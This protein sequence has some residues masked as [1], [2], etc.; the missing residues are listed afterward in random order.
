MLLFLPRLGLRRGFAVLGG[1][2]GDETGDERV[3]P[4]LGV[5]D[6]AI[7]EPEARDQRS[8]MGACGLDG[9]RRELRRPRRARFED[10]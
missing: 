3:E 1:R 9:S 10:V 6:L 5:T 4:S 7:E 2:R 8:D